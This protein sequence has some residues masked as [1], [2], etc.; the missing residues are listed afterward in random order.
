MANNPYGVREDVWQKMGAS[1]RQKV[2]SASQSG[3]QSP[4][5]SG[6]GWKVFC[7]GLLF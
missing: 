4:A 2:A 1:D 3:E 5:W 7:R 6:E